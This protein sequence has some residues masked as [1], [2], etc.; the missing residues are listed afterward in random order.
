MRHTGVSL[1]MLM[2]SWLEMTSHSPSDAI[3]ITSSSDV[4]S[5]SRMSGVDTYTPYRLSAQQPQKEVE[6]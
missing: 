5:S 1:M 2:A 6:K 3:I 4:R